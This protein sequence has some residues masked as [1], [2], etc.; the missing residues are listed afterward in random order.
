MS[1]SIA[2]VRIS[3]QC[4]RCKIPLIA[5]EW[6]E[7][8]SANETV[9]IWRCPICGKEFE[10]VDTKTNQTMSDDELIE[11]FFPTLLVA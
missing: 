10:T 4:D 5:P 6:S 1:T 9:H 2:S 8:V 7:V 11:D 3:A